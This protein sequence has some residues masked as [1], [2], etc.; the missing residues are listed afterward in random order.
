[1]F[2][3]IVLRGS[4]LPGDN[5]HDSK[6]NQTLTTWLAEWEAPSKL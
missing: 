4:T 3:V 6:R 1:M 5:S 2:L